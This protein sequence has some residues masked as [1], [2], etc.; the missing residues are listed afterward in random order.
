MTLRA[1]DSRLE[2]TLRDEIGVTTVGRGAVN[3]IGRCKAEVPVA[4]FARTM[5]CV[6]AGSY[7]LH[8]RE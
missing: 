5:K 7:E 1:S 2:Q 8:Y 4:W 3:V 6:F